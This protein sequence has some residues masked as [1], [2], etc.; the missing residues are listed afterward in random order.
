MS[1]AGASLD[2]P[3][4]KGDNMNK[5][6]TRRGLKSIALQISTAVFRQQTGLLRKWTL[7]LFLLLVCLAFAL[8]GRARADW[9]NQFN[10]AGTTGKIFAMTKDSD[11]NIYIG[12]H[13]TVV[14]RTSANYIAKWNGTSWS[15]L[16][17]GMN[18][19]VNALAWD[20]TNDLLYAGRKLYHGWRYRGQPCCQMERDGLGSSGRR[21]KW[22][23]QGPGV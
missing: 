5:W 9:S 7:S 15:A 20:S 13:F 18:A 3:Q 12:G 10:V 4:Q 21:N 6:N 14:G 17:T 1:W 23:C 2:L 19:E 16:G 22:C 11:G 8:T